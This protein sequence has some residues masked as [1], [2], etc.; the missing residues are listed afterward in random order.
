MVWESLQDN[1]NFRCYQFTE[2]QWLNH[3]FI[4]QKWK[5]SDSV[6]SSSLQPGG[7]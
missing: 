5:W 7:L 3:G 1:S 2:A 4:D 6:V